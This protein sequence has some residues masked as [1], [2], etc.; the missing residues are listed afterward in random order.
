MTEF[1]KSQTDGRPRISEETIRKIKWRLLPLVMVMYVVAFIDRA[2]VG[3]AAHH[4]KDDLGITASQFGLI[5]GLFFVGYFIFEVPSNILLQRFG[6]RRWIA[7]IALSWGILAVLTGFTTGVVSL[8]VVRVLLGIA[9]A[10]FFPG[11]LLYLTYWFPE[12]ERARTISMFIVAVPVATVIAGPTSGLILDHINW[13]GLASWRW[14][15]IL[16]GG[17]AILM[18][19]LALK[20]LTDDPRKAAWLTQDEQDTVIGE[21]TAEQHDKEQ[22]HGSMSWKAVLTNP[23]VFAL[24]FIYFSKS[25]AMYALVFFT[26][27]IV[28]GLSSHFD[29]TQVGLITALPYLISIVGMVIWARHS[30]RTG[31]RRFHVAG[32]YM[33]GAIALVGL[34]I[35]NDTLV[36]S[37]VLLCVVIL[38]LSIPYGPFWSLPSMFLTGAA[39]ASGLAWINAV[40]N[41][42]GFVGPFAL[43]S[44]IDRTGTVFSGLF[45]VAGLVFAASVLTM[46][47]KVVTQVGSA[48]EAETTTRP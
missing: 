32:P 39:A 5:A 30:D 13:G 1:N 21:L 47:L 19:P 38:M 35:W 18:A 40:A 27:T 28:A 24:A 7:R 2:N 20:F 10:G 46:R 3:F 37:V 12:R 44:V 23:R 36:L 6:A 9:E 33:A 31:E 16:Q 34:G 22:T 42:G 11:V 8:S 15:F 48:K 29:A 41:L 43:G 4:L 45:I 25:S 26:P 17:V 14:M